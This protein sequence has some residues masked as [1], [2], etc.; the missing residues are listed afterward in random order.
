MKRFDVPTGPRFCTLTGNQDFPPWKKE[1]S[2][3]GRDTVDGRNPANHLVSMKPYEKWDVLHINWCRIS[4]IN[5][6]FPNGPHRFDVD[7]NIFEKD[8]HLGG[9]INGG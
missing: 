8:L 6:I 9:S 5:R 4:S 7:I 3:E 2:Q 1:K